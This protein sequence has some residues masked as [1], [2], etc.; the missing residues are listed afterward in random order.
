MVKFSEQ[1]VRRG[2]L[3]CLLRSDPA[4]IGKPLQNL[5]RGLASTMEQVCMDQPQPLYQRSSSAMPPLCRLICQAGASPYP[6]RSRP[7]MS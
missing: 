2:K 7:R 1:M 5:R 3:V 4:G 6:A